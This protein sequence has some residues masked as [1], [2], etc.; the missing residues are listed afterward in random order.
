MDDATD[1]LIRDPAAGANQSGLRDQNARLV[2]SY[3]RRHGQ[4]AG[5]EIARR[6]GLS[7]QTV[8]NIL[9]A[10]EA[11]N[12]LRRGAA[13]KERGKVGKPS[14]P[15]ELNPGGV[16]SIGLNIGRRSAELVL[17]DFHGAPIGSQA[18]AYP[19]PVIETVFDFIK[20]GLERLYAKCPEARTRTTGIGVARPNEIWN[21]LEQVNAPEDAMKQ[22]KDLSLDAEISAVTGLDVFIE[23]DATSACV[24]EHLL[25]RGSEFSDF[26]HIFIGAFVGGGLV[27]D[28]KIV[29]GPTRNAA[30]IGPLP[31]PDGRGGVV[32]LLSRT[33]LYL[34]EED[35][36]EA[37]RDP[38]GLRRSPADWS[39]FEPQVTE[40]IGRTAQYLSIAALSIAS[41]VEVEAI[42]IDGAMPKDVC[43]R[44][45][46]E[47]DRHFDTLDRTGLER[48][49]IEA[50]AVGRRARSIGAA[51]LP[52]H[53]RFFVA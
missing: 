7:A 21:W 34:L 52:I 39:A 23:N 10:L 48:P 42:L 9:R 2:L 27:L 43:Q 38:V 51:L 49:R 26:A 30:A 36:A 40:W 16:Y 12:L 53:S 17:V 20:T 15:M 1:S 4:M 45:V 46:D 31:V 24:A 18:I 44:L 41:V 37:G 22:W 32:P 29:W 13:V 33:S 3:L 35:L 47:T 50:G 8:S 6:S 25:G 28:G 11:Q 5:A 19:Y 14:V